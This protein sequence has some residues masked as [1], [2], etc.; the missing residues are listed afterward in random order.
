MLVFTDK[1]QTGLNGEPGIKHSEWSER[2]KADDLPDLRRW[3]CQSHH[4]MALEGRRGQRWGGWWEK[5][6]ASLFVC[7]LARQRGVC[8]RLRRFSP[9]LHSSACLQRALEKK[10]LSSSWGSMASTHLAPAALLRRGTVV[11]KR[12]PPEGPL[13]ERW[14]KWFQFSD[15]CF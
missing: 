3:N 7:P 13:H 11:S 15:W 10:G 1:R 12:G 14:K 2:Q 9:V 5:G 8:Q 4:R 6:A